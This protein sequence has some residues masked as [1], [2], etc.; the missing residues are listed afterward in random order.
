[1]DIVTKIRIAYLW[2]NIGASCLTALLLIAWSFYKSGLQE[3]F[4]SLENMSGLLFGSIGIAIA[5][6]IILWFVWIG[7]W[8]IIWI[9]YC[10]LIMPVT[11]LAGK[12]KMCGYM[13]KYQRKRIWN[14]PYLL[15]LIYIGKQK[16]T[17]FQDT[18]FIVLNDCSQ[19]SACWRLPG[20]RK[21]VEESN[22]E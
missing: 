16:S 19:S 20:S 6:F 14:A 9:C 2:G 21:K 8:G 12:L 13:G 15:P 10:L 1:M 18:F 17:F 5:T 7:M 3:I 11:K 22:K 4:S